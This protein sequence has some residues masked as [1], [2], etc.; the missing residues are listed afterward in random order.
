MLERRCLRR[1]DRITAFSDYTR[2]L[3]RRMHGSVIADRVRVIHGW[4]DLSHFRIVPDRA[5]AR[6]RLG[7]PVDVPLFFTLRRLV[8]RMGLDRLIEALSLVNKAGRRCHLVIAGDGPLRGDLRRL[9]G[10]LG[11]ESSVQFVGRVDDAA[12]PMMYG[13]ADAFVL[14]TRALECFGLIAVEAL[15]CGVPVL[16]TPTG[17]IPEIINRIE[18]Q[19]LARNTG[20]EAIGDLLARFLEDRLPRHSASDLR[21]HVQSRYALDDRVAELAGAALGTPADGS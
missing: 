16:A 15:A 3:I 6:T 2:G 18:P 8:P 14:P 11:L 20:A 4:A 1:T 17:A 21:A 10:D 19:W 12:L 9:A 13:A 5:A 7:W